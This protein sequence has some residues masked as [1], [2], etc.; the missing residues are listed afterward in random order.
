MEV[1]GDKL[2]T[3]CDAHMMCICMSLVRTYRTIRSSPTSHWAAGDY[4]RGW[5]LSRTASICTRLPLSSRLPAISV[6]VCGGRGEVEVE[7]RRRDRGR[8]RGKE[9]EEEWGKRER[10]RTKGRKREKEEKEEGKEEG[11]RK[12]GRGRGVKDGERRDYRIDEQDETGVRGKIVGRAAVT[13]GIK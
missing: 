12:K 13:A 8:K 9:R 3:P 2:M 1:Q 10:G 6:R 5:E 11:E 7:E 4:L